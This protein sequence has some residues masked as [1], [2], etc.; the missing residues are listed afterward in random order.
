VLAAR[1]VIDCGRNLRIGFVE[2]T[3]HPGIFHVVSL[4][5]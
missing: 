2:R 5:L 3:V 1:F 4:I